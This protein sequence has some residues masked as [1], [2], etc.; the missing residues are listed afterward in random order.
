MLYIILPALYGQV[1]I[2]YNPK[3]HYEARNIVLISSKP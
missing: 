1:I 3:G 2:F